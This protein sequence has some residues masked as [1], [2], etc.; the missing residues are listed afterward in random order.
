[1]TNWKWTEKRR[2]NDPCEPVSEMYC[3]KRFGK[4][5][6]GYAIRLQYKRD[7]SG[8]ETGEVECYI[9]IEYSRC[10]KGDYDDM[11]ETWWR[12]ERYGDY[13][14]QLP[15]LIRVCFTLQDAIDEVSRRHKEV[16]DIVKQYLDFPDE[17]TISGAVAKLAAI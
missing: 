10:H 11:H 5:C 9:A 13:L 16:Y 14:F 7:V 17:N 2:R 8:N 1:M 4:Y 6:R 3:L 12:E 15:G